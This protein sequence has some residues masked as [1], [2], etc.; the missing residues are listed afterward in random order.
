MLGCS[1]PIHDRH[2]NIHE[3]QLVGVYVFDILVDVSDW[4]SFGLHPLMNEPQGLLPVVCLVRLQVMVYLQDCLQA[5]NVEIV[6]INN[7][8]LGAW[9]LTLV[10]DA[11][12]ELLS[13]LNI[14]LCLSVW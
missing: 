13:K 5:Q 4:T 8:D 2:G 9:A 6:V 1:E 11:A 12:S 10:S 3:H 7:E 14:T